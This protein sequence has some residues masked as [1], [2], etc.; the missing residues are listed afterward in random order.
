[1]VHALRASKGH[2]P[3]YIRNEVK[4]WTTKGH[5]NSL[6]EKYYTFSKILGPGH[7]RMQKKKKKYLTSQ[8]TQVCNDSVGMC[9]KKWYH[10][11]YSTS[12]LEYLLIHIKPECEGRK[13]ILLI[14]FN[15]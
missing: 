10:Q 15:S 12:Y 5:H 4:F 13:G 11:T 3:E 14:F 8:I 9:K 2:P 6:S 1:M 7:K